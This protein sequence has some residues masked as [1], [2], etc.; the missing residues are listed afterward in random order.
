[1]DQQ[2]IATIVYRYLQD[3]DNEL[4]MEFRRKIKSK[5]NIKVFNRNKQGVPTME[6]LIESFKREKDSLSHEEQNDSIE[7]VEEFVSLKINEQRE[8]EL[9]SCNEVLLF[10]DNNN[11]SVYVDV[12]ILVNWN[13][14][15]KRLLIIDRSKNVIL[16]KLIDNTIKLETLIFGLFVRIVLDKSEIESYGKNLTLKFNKILQ[17]PKFIK[18]FKGA[19]KDEDKDEDV[20]VTYEKQPSKENAEKAKRLQ[21]PKNFFG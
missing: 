11:P 8:Q 21:L 14:G 15:N 4:A 20:M 12:K 19:E 17:V 5:E 2:M 7:I 6:Q 10:T 1:M 18:A 16:D 3:K 9:F 13:T